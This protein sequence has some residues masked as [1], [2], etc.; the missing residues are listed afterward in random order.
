[1]HNWNKVLKKEPKKISGTQTL[2]N[3]KW[4]GLLEQTI[5]L[6]IF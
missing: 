4:S 5:S 2:K 1:M 6:Q 3:P